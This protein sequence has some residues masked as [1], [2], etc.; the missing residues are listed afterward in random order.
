M[1]A[2]GK[3]EEVKANNEVQKIYIGEEA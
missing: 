3:P 2:E 1:I